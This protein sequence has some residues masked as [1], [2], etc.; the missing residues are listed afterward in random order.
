M[1]FRLA[2]YTELLATITVATPELSDPSRRGCGLQLN[3]VGK[4]ALLACKTTGGRLQP[5]P[6]TSYAHRLTVFGPCWWSE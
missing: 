1:S 5:K 3:Y 6:T 4:D 2:T